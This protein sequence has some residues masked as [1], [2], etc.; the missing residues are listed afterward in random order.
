MCTDARF[1]GAAARARRAPGPG[2]YVLGLVG[3]AGGGKSTV[4]RAL[5]ADG[6]RVVEADRVGHEVTERDPDVRAALVADYGPGVYRADGTL[7]RA[8]VAARV[9]ADPAALERLNRV[10]HPR[11]VERLRAEVAAASEGLLVLDAALLL[12]WGFERECDGVLAVLASRERSVERLVRSRGWSEAEARAR[13]AAARSNESF[14]A[15]ADE[16]VWNEGGADEL[17]A[18]ARAACARLRARREAAR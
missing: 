6:A 10:V 16:T 5:A 13:L 1:E 2:P 9:F 15:H 7:D 17:L 18:A 11:I 12:D 8:Q 3:P 4:A 14:A